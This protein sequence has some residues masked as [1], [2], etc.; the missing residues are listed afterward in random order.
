LHVNLDTATS[1]TL[2]VGDTKVI[3][4]DMVDENNVTTASAPVTILS[5]NSKVAAVAGVTVTAGSPGGAGLIAVCSP[6]NCGAGL[7]LPIYSNLFQVAVNGSSP[8]TNVYATTSFAPPS[9]TTP[10]MIPIDTSKTPPAAGTAINLPG[11]PNSLVFAP[12]GSR[13]FMG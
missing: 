4:A 1:A 3:Q 11:V 10:T 12:S 6:P 7:N 5:N 8:A 2:N 13:A 9:G